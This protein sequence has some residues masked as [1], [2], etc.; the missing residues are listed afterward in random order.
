[1]T[2]SHSEP[3][4]EAQLESLLSTLLEEEPGRDVMPPAPQD[5]PPDVIELAETAR[6]LRASTQ[7]VPLPAGRTAVRRALVATAHDAESRRRS[8]QPAR[9]RWM[10]APVAAAMAATFIMAF[11]LGAGVLDGFAVP[12]S[13]LYGLRLELDALRVAVVP[14]PVSKAELLVRAAHLRIA[15]IDEMVSSGDTRGVAQAAAALD[16]EAGWL[17]AITA[18][19]A[20]AD[21]QRLADAIEH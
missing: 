10:W 16:R 2:D 15:E 19:L 3:I 17:Q 1:M 5:I 8:T 9:R 11:G 13:P 14:S 20:P 12:G 21:R 7:W 6:L 4:N 18:L